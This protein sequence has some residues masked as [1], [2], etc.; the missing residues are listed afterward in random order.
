[1]NILAVC[2][3]TELQGMDRNFGA[4]LRITPFPIMFKLI[5]LDFFLII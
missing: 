2:K 1:M 3:H 4:V 5:C